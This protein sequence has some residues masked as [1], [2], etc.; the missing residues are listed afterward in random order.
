MEFC[1]T[2][3]EFDNKIGMVPKEHEMT[4]IEVDTVRMDLE[5]GERTDKEVDVADMECERNDT[6]FD[7]TI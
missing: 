6:D 2:D 3:M 5:T 1:T 7:T 4:D